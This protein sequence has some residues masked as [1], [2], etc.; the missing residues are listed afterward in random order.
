MKKNMLFIFA[1]SIAGAANGHDI[2]SKDYEEF[3]KR[4][5]EKAGEFSAVT[6]EIIKIVKYHDEGEHAVEAHKKGAQKEINEAANGGKSWL[7]RD[8]AK[9]MAAGAGVLLLME[10]AGVALIK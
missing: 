4:I 1:L 8:T 10:I 6:K 2:S 7:N 5:D 9:R 3:Q